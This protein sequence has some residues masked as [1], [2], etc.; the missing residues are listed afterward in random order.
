MNKSVYWVVFLVF[1]VAITSCEEPTNQKVVE[2][3]KDY[4]F[5]TDSLV[6][7]IYVFSDEQKPLDERFLRM[8]RMQNDTDSSFVVERF[9]SSFKITEGFTHELNDSLT[10]IDHMVVDRDGLKRK[11][12]LTSNY[13]F[14]V[15]K[16]M[17][18]HFITDFP[19][20]IDSTVIV[21]DSKKH[22]VDANYSF[23]LFGKEIPAIHV[24]DTV[25]WYELN[26]NSNEARERSVVTDNI[27]AKGYG[28]VEW[29]AEDKS[30]VYTLRKI[31]S[32]KW[33]SEN[34]QAPQVRF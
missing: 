13:N 4:F 23:T 34:A 18:A 28:L 2:S 17:V 27:Y 29:G 16:D 11:S 32:D 12:K 22:I 1:S 10:I 33:W 6:P 5:P 20:V 31:L 9:N 21:Q 24:K 7:Y 3:Y 8:Y 30:V 19:G 14:P 15:F 26:A 25:R